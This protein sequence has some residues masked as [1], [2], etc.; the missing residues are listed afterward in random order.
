M[1]LCFSHHRIALKY[2]ESKDD[3]LRHARQE[4]AAA[5]KEEPEGKGSASILESFFESG[6]ED[7]DIVGLVI[8]MFLAGVDTVRCKNYTF[9]LFT[10]TH[11]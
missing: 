6:L 11:K 5:G 1:L 7:K 10:L 8:D 3:E 9:C 2:V 4:R